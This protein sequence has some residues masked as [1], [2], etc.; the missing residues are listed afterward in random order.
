MRCMQ[1]AAEAAPLLMGHEDA[2]L[3][4]MS[5]F[6]APMDAGCSGSEALAWAL[7]EDRWLRDSRVRSRVRT[8][9]GVYCHMHLYIWPLLACLQFECL[10]ISAYG[11]CSH[12]RS[13]GGC[14]AKSRRPK[15]GTGCCCASVC[16]ACWR[17]PT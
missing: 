4:H 15:C 16:E 7:E 1:G 12:A 5:G 14:L 10:C 2:A 8:C 13:K 3:R 9:L 17:W 11:P 6:E